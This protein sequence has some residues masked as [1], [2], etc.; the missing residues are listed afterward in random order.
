MNDNNRK[1]IKTIFTKNVKEIA[2]NKQRNE[3]EDFTKIPFFFFLLLI[4]FNFSNKNISS[5][6]NLY[7]NQIVI[8]IYLKLRHI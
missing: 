5:F 3:F 7:Y 2:A 1:I 8:I 4:I 6:I